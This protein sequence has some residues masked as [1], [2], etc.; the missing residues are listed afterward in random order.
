VGG[1]GGI[2]AG[3]LALRYQPSGC[4][5]CSSGAGGG[6]GGGYSGGGAGGGG[7]SECEGGGGGGGAGG[8]SSYV[9]KTATGL[10]SRNGGA[11]E[12]PGKIII[13]W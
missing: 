1:S 4:T 9:E 7:G 12:G 10:T 13:S 5:S 6:G 11:T 3:E 2:N 8:G